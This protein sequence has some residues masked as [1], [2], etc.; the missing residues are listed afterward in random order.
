MSI[1]RAISAHRTS[2]DHNARAPRR[3]K[4]KIAVRITT[5]PAHKKKRD[6]SRDFATTGADSCGAVGE[7]MG[8]NCNRRASGSATWRLHDA[9]RDEFACVIFVETSLIFSWNEDERRQ[10]SR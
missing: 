1:S 7:V 5:P 6:S 10:Q 3:T 9:G 2:D 4:Y 8:K